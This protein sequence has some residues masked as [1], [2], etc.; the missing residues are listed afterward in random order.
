MNIIKTRVSLFGSECSLHLGYYEDT[1]DNDLCVEFC[2]LHGIFVDFDNLPQF[3]QI[4]LFKLIY[5]DI[6]RLDS[7]EQ[8]D[9][10]LSGDE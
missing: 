4:M 9:N 3:L 10:L 5:D 6:I 7:L 1:F 8:L 2:K